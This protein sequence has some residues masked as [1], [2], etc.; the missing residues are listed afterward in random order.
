M[1]S[2]LCL[3]VVAAFSCFG[4]N[5]AKA[6]RVQRITQ[7][8]NVEVWKIDEPNV[9]QRDTAYNDIIFKQGDTVNVTAGGC[10]QT[11]GHGKTWKRYVDPQGPN[12]DHIY[13]GL[14]KLPGMPGLTRLQDFLG[15]G[16]VFKVPDDASGDLTVHLGYEDDGYS[17]NGYSGHDDG[18]GDQCKNVEN[19]WVQLV[20]VHK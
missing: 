7:V 19:A 17:D 11:G 5:Q 20:I 6:E 4:T 3:F 15:G 2:L 9:G 14:V 13:H 1:R 18:T 8:G 16:G 12:S 10:V